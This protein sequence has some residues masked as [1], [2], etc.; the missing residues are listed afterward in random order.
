MRH[1]SS[2]IAVLA[3]AIAAPAIAGKGGNGNGGN[4]GGGIGGGGGGNNVTPTGACSVDGT[5]VHGTGLPTWT[6]MN[7]MV[8]DASGTSG[9]VIGYTADGTRSIEVPDRAGPATYEFA[10]ETYGNDG[11]KYAVF[12]SCSA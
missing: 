7:F 9:W 4:S 6:L 8:T 3:L 5:V 2:I 11:E 12:A 10:G 1:I